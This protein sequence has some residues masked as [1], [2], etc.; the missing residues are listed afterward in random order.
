MLHWLSYIYFEPVGTLKKCVYTFM[1]FTC[2]EQM[3]T[4][5]DMHGV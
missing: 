1:K 2:I 4:N 5:E 3:L